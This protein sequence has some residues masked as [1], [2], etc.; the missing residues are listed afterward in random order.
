MVCSQFSGEQ[1]GIQNTPSCPV[2]PLPGLVSLGETVTVVPNCAASSWCQ[3]GQGPGQ[4]TQGERC[5]TE[6]DPTLGR[7]CGRAAPAGSGA[8]GWA[9][10]AS[11]TQTKYPALWRSEKFLALAWPGLSG[12]KSP[13]FTEPGLLSALSLFFLFLTP[14]AQADWQTYPSME[15]RALALG[16]SQEEGGS[17]SQRRRTDMESETV[18]EQETE[19]DGHCHKVRDVVRETERHWETER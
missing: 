14:G 12:F 11:P 18:W 17:A 13:S 1:W 10:P 16:S 15:G 8:P 19:Q 4:D 2:C 6:G 7:G 9:P 5:H 3:S